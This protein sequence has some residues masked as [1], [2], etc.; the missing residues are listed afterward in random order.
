M[1]MQI[2]EWLIALGVWIMPRRHPHRV[3]WQ[4][5]VERAERLL[6]ANP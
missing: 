1:R 2:G 6:Q 3:C 5:G 4:E